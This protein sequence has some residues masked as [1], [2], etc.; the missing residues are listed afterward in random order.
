MLIDLSIALFLPWISKMRSMLLAVRRARFSKTA[1][2]G[3]GH[4]EAGGGVHHIAPRAVVG[5]VHADDVAK[6]AAEGPEA[7]ESDVEADVGDVVARFAQEEH[8]ALD[9]AALQV[10]VRRL[11]ESRSERADKVSF[12]DACHP[13]QGGDVQRLGVGAVHGVAGP[14]HTAI[15]LFDGACHLIIFAQAA[16]PPFPS[17]LAGKGKPTSPASGE[18]KPYIA[19]CLW[20][21]DNQP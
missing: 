7:A 4:R 2:S 15:E 6:G 21:L 17:T 8:G 11:A 10:A 9:P 3:P 1:G 12:G 19:C 13:R 14:E 20:G 18:V 16:R 5:G